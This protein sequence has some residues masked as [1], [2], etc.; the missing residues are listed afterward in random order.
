MAVDLTRGANGAGRDQAELILELGA[1]NVVLDV[2]S[3]ESRMLKVTSNAL[4]E[5]LS[6]FLHQRLTSHGDTAADDDL[7][8]AESQSQVG[9]HGA[10]IVANDGPDLVVIR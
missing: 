3:L 9:A 1:H 4:L 2:V 6:D 5:A 8:E 10:Q 7:F